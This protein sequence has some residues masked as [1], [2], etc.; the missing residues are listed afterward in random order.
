MLPKDRILIHKL[1]RRISFLIIIIFALSYWVRLNYYDLESKSYDL[2]DAQHELLES[3]NKINILQ[4]KLDSFNKPIKAKK[5]IKKSKNIIN[6]KKIEIKKDTI[7]PQ[8]SDT[9]LPE[10]QLSDTL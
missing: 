2:E 7:I 1:R 4:S 10:A 9:T 5:E 3:Q 8:K 6:T